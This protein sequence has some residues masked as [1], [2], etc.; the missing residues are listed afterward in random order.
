MSSPITCTGPGGRIQGRCRCLR[1]SRRPTRSG[2]TG[3]SSGHTLALSAPGWSRSSGPRSCSWSPVVV[4]AGVVGGAVARS[5]G[6]RAAVVGGAVGAAA[7]PV[8]LGPVDAVVVS[9]GA[10]VVLVVAMGGRRRL[11][12]RPVVVASVDG[13]AARQRF[14]GHL[15]TVAAPDRCHCGGDGEPGDHAD[16]G[17]EPLARPCS[18]RAAACLPD[19]WLALAEC[20]GVMC[21]PPSVPPAV[22]EPGEG[23]A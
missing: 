20:G 23:G 14:N 5:V 3:S 18:L 13:L 1:R 4:G 12:G 8:E 9:G 21:Q 17:Q 15:L 7:A 22:G 10:D 6:A 19:G 11:R 16:R 2:R